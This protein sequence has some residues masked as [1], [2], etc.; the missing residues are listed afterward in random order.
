MQFRAGLRPV[1]QSNRAGALGQLGD[2]LRAKGAP[3]ITPVRHEP[4]A[5]TDER[6]ALSGVIKEVVKQGLKRLKSPPLPRPDTPSELTPP[7]PTPSEPPNIGAEPEPFGPFTN[8][9]ERPEAPLRPVAPVAPEPGRAPTPPMQSAP[10]QAPRHPGED[11]VPV[12][13]AEP[14]EWAW[15]DVDFENERTTWPA[16][17]EEGRRRRKRV[18]TYVIYRPPHTEV[19]ELE[20]GAPNRTIGEPELHTLGPGGMKEA[21]RRRAII[22]SRLGIAADTRS[23]PNRTH[24]TPGVRTLQSLLISPT[25]GN[26]GPVPHR[27]N[28]VEGERR[29]G[30]YRRHQLSDLDSYLH[31]V[32]PR[33]MPD[34]IG[35]RTKR[36]KQ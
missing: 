36:K 15:I 10:D 9:D 21:D 11:W 7:E 14:D 25:Y 18:P 33:D 8:R 29:S 34:H 1:L 31:V 26:W 13:Q 17:D 6:H 22:R 2:D 20:A 19:Y 5:D 28:Q 32:A 27:E 4:D 24:E 12:T 16:K 23:S 30:F 3:P 35:A